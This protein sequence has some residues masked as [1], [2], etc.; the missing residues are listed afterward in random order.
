MRMSLSVILF[1]ILLVNSVSILLHIVT[2]K[3][4]RTFAVTVVSINLDDVL[5]GL[6]LCII[7]IVDIKY[8]GSFV[9]KEELWRSNLLCFIAF[10]TILLFSILGPLFLV[11]LSLSRLMF[12]I[13]PLDTLFKHTKFVTKP[14]FLISIA[15]FTLTLALTL[16]VKSREKI[17]PFSLCLPFIDPTGSIH[18]IKV[19]TWSVGIFQYMASLGIIIIHILLVYKYLQSQKTMQ[20]LNSDKKY[21]TPTQITATV[22]NIF[23]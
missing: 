15:A 17:L 18:V 11:L 19:I 21:F 14:L 8:Q 13:F 22:Y 4:S 23:V 20:K 5:C 9:V 7:L 6:Y 10:D 2:G 3:F 1:C 12:V 16:S